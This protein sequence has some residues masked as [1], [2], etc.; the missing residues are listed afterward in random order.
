MKRKEKIN[1]IGFY[2]ISLIEFESFECL[3]NS[4][5]T[6]AIKII[7]FLR[8]KNRFENSN[9]SQLQL[10]L[11][12]CTKNIRESWYTQGQKP[13]T[14][15]PHEYLN[16][17]LQRKGL[18]M[19]FFDVHATHKKNKKKWHS[20][21]IIYIHLCYSASFASLSTISCRKKMRREKT[22]VLFY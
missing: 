2:W 8:N 10:M 3:C 18:F 19:F 20:S 6:C 11:Y 5:K 1:R 7:F 17:F 15:S 16:N 9:W 21:K 4:M 12:V 13:V 22:T 14:T